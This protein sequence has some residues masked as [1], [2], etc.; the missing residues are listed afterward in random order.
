MEN[1]N[2]LRAVVYGKYASIADLARYLGW[3]RQ[4]ATNIV[5]K[6]QEPSL[7][8]VNL[9]ANALGMPFEDAAQFFLQAGSHKCDT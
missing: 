7:K 5:N 3:T 1:M 9:L 4:K 2:S 8:E 6:K